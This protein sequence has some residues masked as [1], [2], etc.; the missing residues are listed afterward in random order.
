[1]PLYFFNARE[2]SAF[3]PDA[4]GVEL[5]GLPAARKLAVRALTEH[6]ENI[7]PDDGDHKDMAIEVTDEAG[8]PLFEASLKFRLTLD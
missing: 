3:T 1:M 6:A 8:T 7:L 5:D 4:T 2:G